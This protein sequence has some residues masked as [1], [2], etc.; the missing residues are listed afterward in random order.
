MWKPWPVI[1]VRSA[2]DKDSISFFRFSNFQWN[3]AF[4]KVSSTTVFVPNTAV[5]AQHTNVFYQKPLIL[6][7]IPLYLPPKYH[8]I[9]PLYCCIC[10]EY[11]Y[12]WPHIPLNFLPNTTILHQIPLLLPI[13]LRKIPLYLQK[14]SL[15][16]LTAIVRFLYNCL[17]PK[18]CS[19]GPTY[20]C[21]LPE[22][23][24]FA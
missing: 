24:D 1:I 15:N 19:I 23:I 22:T 8:C 3:S 4:I 5:L 14:K 7:K 11:H 18:Y 20:Q 21:I 10:P 6:P 2:N 16:F 12:I 13:S 17:C 9:W